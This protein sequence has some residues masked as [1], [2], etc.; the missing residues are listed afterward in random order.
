MKIKKEKEED[1]EKEKV[2]EFLKKIEGEEMEVEWMEMKE[3]LDYEMRNEKK[4][5]GL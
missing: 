2:K 1:K 4:N 5:E 3:I